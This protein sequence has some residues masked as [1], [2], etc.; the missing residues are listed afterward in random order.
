MLIIFGG[1]PGTGKTTIAR[2]LARRIRA[3]HLR[4]DTLEQEM[5]NVGIVTK[6]DFGPRG[7]IVAYALAAD[8]LKVGLDVIADSVNPLNIT[9]SA[10]R[11]VATGSGAPYLEV[12]ITCQDAKE[13]R[14]RV[15]TRKPDIP[16]L[17]LPDWPAVMNREYDLWETEHLILDTSRMSPEECVQQIVS[18]LLSA[19]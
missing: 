11:A 17:E 19:N 13:H 2:M 5:L 4:I 9:R 1:L 8:N 12:E 15:E 14:R 18:A 7:Y 16:G 6:E 10:W 3:M